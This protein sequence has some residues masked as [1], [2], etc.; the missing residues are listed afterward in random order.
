MRPYKST[1]NLN[2]LNWGMPS[3]HSQIITLTAIF[4]ILYLFN[5]NFKY[6]NIGILILFIS[7]IIISYSRIYF[8][9]HNL[10]QVII[11]NIIGFIFGIIGYY[12]YK[13][14]YNYYI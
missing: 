9:Y 11:G 5:S 10:F 14:I 1:Y 13:N 4:W 3:G 6:K 12:L 2:I 7:I 8:N